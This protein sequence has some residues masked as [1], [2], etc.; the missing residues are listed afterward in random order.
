[1]FDKKINPVGFL[2]LIR[3]HKS[4]SFNRSR[5]CAKVDLKKKTMHEKKFIYM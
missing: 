1:M 2:N 3:N 4:L 5:Y